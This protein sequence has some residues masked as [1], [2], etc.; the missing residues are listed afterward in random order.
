MRL[1]RRYGP[2]FQ[3]A[4]PGRHLVVVLGYELVKELRD[5]RHL[6]KLG[7]APL[8]NVR[9]FAGDGLF[10][11]SRV[12]GQPK[13]YVRDVIRWQADNLWKLIQAGAVVYVSGDASKMAPGMRAAFAAIFREK[14]GLSADLAE[15]WLA[16][17]ASENRN[18]VDVRPSS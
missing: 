10:T 17:L 18:L 8:K 2:I 4:L 12:A 9:A 7:W 3:L 14:T 11:S 13:T 5:E 1:A 15:A 6:D 16:E